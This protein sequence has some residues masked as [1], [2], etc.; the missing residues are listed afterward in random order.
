MVLASYASSVLAA[1]TLQLS[2]TPEWP[3]WTSGDGTSSGLGPDGPWQAVVVG[4]GNFSDLQSVYDFSNLS[5]MITPLYPFNTEITTLLMAGMGGNYSITGSEASN[6]AQILQSQSSDDR[7]ELQAH[8]NAPVGPDVQDFIQIRGVGDQTA[9]TVNG[10]IMAATHGWNITLPSNRSYAA[11][12]GILGLGPPGSIPGLANMSTIPNQ[13]KSSNAIGSNSFGMHIGSVS[14]EILGSMVLG[15]YDQS[16]VIGPV[17]IFAFVQSSPIAWLV[18]IALGAAR[19]ESPFDGINGTMAQLFKGTGGSIIAEELRQVL[20]GPSNTVG[21]APDPTFPYITLPPGSCEAIASYL[22]VTWNPDIGLFIWNSDDKLFPQIINSSAYLEF[23]LI[24]VTSEILKIKVPFKLLNLTLEAPIV[25]TPTP[26]FPCQPSNFSSGTWT[27]GRAFL[28]AAFLG[29]NFDQ[30]IT[31]LAQAPGPTLNQSNIVP[32]ESTDQILAGSQTDASSA[33]VA[34]WNNSWAP[35]DCSMQAL[36]NNSNSSGSAPPSLHQITTGAIAGIVIGTVAGLALL[37][38]SVFLFLRY[39]KFLGTTALGGSHSIGAAELGDPPRNALNP[40]Q[41][42]ET[43]GNPI[44]ESD[45]KENASEIE[46]AGIRHEL[47]ASD[48]VADTTQITEKE[49]PAIKRYLWLS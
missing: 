41:R 12:V 23:S 42:H 8:I 1:R 14:Q 31:F 7:S 33:L 2:W 28:Q 47:P 15:G 17:G 13:L 45:G 46:G 44:F 27:L 4:V 6:T 19:C 18:D 48:C 25:D 35:L 11:E 26:Y 24:G 36:N 21:M 16:R 29:F 20:G 32:I 9:H 5:S 49:K 37:A 43:G 3:Q 30:N 40:G 38:L 34:S 10:F 39:Q 22:P